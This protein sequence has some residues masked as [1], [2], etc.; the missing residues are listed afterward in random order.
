MLTLFAMEFRSNG[1]TDVDIHISFTLIRSLKLLSL[2]C[3]RKEIDLG[4]FFMRIWHVSGAKIAI[5][6]TDFKNPRSIFAGTV[7]TT[8]SKQ[9]DNRGNPLSICTR[10]DVSSIS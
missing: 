4:A 6:N 7:K 3:S 2:F 9:Q 1:I 5:F 10:V 8:K